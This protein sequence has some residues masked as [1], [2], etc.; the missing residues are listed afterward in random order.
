M[1]NVPVSFTGTAVNFEGF[2]DAIIAIP[3]TDEKAKRLADLWL[4]R[5]DLQFVADCLTKINEIDHPERI[6]REALWESAIVGY[7]KC[8]GDSKARFQLSDAKIFRGQTAV[9]ALHRYFVDLRDKHI[10]HD[11]NPFAQ[12]TP[13][14]ALNRGDKPFKIERIICLAGWYLPNLTRPQQPQ[15]LFLLCAFFLQVP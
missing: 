9:L 4:H 8:F 12:C 5:V 1:E 14:A 7:V 10:A 6:M 2:P 3:L 11:E 13:T 15:M